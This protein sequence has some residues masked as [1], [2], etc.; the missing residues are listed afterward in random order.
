MPDI[1]EAVLVWG[2]RIK[3]AINRQVMTLISRYNG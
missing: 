3:K 1:A 2:K